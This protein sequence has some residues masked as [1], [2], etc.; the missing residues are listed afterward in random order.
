M[1]EKV[2]NMD[3]SYSKESDALR[4]L[5]ANHLAYFEKNVEWADYSNWLI[6]LTQ[7]LE[8]NQT[9]HILDK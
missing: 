8:E 1:R 2:D 7:I 6:R 4:K 5:M 3:K 9:P